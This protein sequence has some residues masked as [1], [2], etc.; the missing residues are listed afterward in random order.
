MMKYL[1]CIFLGSFLL[2]F[3]SCQAQV[4][5]ENP[6]E[7]LSQSPSTIHP[8]AP[9]L[10]RV[11][12]IS[13]PN[14]PARITRKIRPMREGKLL[15]ASFQ[16][17]IVYDGSTFS[18]LPKPDGIESW[19]AFDALEDSQGNI[20]IASTHYGVFRYDGKEYEHFTTENGLVHKRTMSLHEDQAGNIWIATMGGISCYDGKSFR[21]Y[22]SQ[23]GLSDQDVSIILEDHSG[24]IWI[25]TRGR[26]YIFDPATQS[27]T[28]VSNSEGKTFNN[29]WAILEDTKNNIWLGGKDG[30]WRYDGTSFTCFS[31]EFT[32]GISEDKQGNIWTISPHKVLSLYEAKSLPGEPVKAQEIYK[33]YNMFFGIHVDKSGAI[34]VGIGTGVFNYNENSIKYFIE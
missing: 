24:K 11:D 29:V 9:F 12:T 34:W 19:D 25:G 30:L 26:A 33:G 1:S 20:W 32:N 31:Q 23:E 22:T 18:K 6:P 2:D 21:N 16:D 10:I 4:R 14:A 3:F 7:L 15:M 27:F 13:L 5:P 28:V 8:S 17:I